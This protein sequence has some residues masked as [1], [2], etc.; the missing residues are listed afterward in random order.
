MLAL[1]VQAMNKFISKFGIECFT[2]AVYHGAFAEVMLAIIH[3]CDEMEASENFK[4]IQEAFVN[5]Y[6]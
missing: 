1:E 3:P 5:A 6:V 4:L 2:S